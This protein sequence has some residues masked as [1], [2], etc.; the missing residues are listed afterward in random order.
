VSRWLP[1]TYYVEVVNF[2][3]RPALAAAQPTVEV[4]IGGDTWSFHWPSE[5]SA[6]RWVVCAIDGVT[7]TVI[8]GGL[9][10]H[11]RRRQ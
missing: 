9:P 3:G 2:S 1:L 4:A 8:P 6:D 11:L 7:R 5:A 10:A